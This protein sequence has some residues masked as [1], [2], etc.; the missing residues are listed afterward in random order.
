MDVQGNR[1]RGVQR[2]PVTSQRD[3]SM[4]IITFQQLAWNDHHAQLVDIS[5]VG[6]GIESSQRIDPGLV[7]FKERIGGYKSGVLM[8]SR[9]C[10]DGFRSGI[11]F[12]SLS[13]HEE[14]YLQE[15]VLT[16]VPREPVRDP[17]QII[18][19]IMES[20]KKELPEL[21]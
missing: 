20:V 9:Q 18:S 4:G 7:W 16:A 5:V 1:T 11:K 10:G 8:W 2:Y 12:V 3:C 6:I 19:A 14:S 15:Q 17:Q 13:R 21:V